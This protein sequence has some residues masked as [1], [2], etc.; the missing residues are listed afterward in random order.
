MF[1]MMKNY[2]YELIAKAIFSDTFV[3]VDNKEKMISIDEEDI[4]WK[5][6]IDNKFERIDDW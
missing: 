6:D 1:Q 4:A 3:L 5:S 2:P